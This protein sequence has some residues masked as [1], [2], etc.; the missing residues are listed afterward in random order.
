MS[1]I[2]DSA[3]RVTPT[4]MGL[5]RSS[6][7][8]VRPE[9][10]LVTGATW[11]GTFVSAGRRLG[12]SSS[13]SVATDVSAVA[14]AKSSSENVMQRPEASPCIVSVSNAA[15]LTDTESSARTCPVRQKSVQKEQSHAAMS[16]AALAAAAAM[17]AAALAAATAASFAAFAA[18]AAQT[19]LRCDQGPFF[20]L[21]VP[22]TPPTHARL[23]QPS[24][25]SP[26]W[27]TFPFG[28]VQDPPYPPTPGAFSVTTSRKQVPVQRMDVSLVCD[29]S[30]TASPMVPFFHM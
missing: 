12:V 30:V 21:H 26:V 13:M 29:A 18:A 6:A 28:H 7:A 14:D 11:A 10:K 23:P 1:T 22:E 5:P 9:R 24:L 20:E 17:S 4:A 27:Y 19:T 2:C 8:R 15:W 16:A 25:L 3:S